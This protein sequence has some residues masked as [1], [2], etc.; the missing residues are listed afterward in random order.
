[1]FSHFFRIIVRYFI[2][3][4]NKNIGL[5]SASEPIITYQRVTFNEVIVELTVSPCVL[6]EALVISYTYI[7]TRLSKKRQADIVETGEFSNV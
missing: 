7:L 5:F 1:M 6:D 3:H 2:V 4:H